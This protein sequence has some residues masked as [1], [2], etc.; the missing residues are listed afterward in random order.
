MLNALRVAVPLQCC[1]SS[2]SWAVVVKLGCGGSGY[3]DGTSGIKHMLLLGAHVLHQGGALVGAPVSGV[4][5]APVMPVILAGNQCELGA[6]H[7]QHSSA[8][9]WPRRYQVLFLSARLPVDCTG[10]S[11]TSRHVDVHTAVPV[12]LQAECPA[13]GLIASHK[14]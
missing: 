6:Q 5:A 13:G 10:C 3:C 7:V 14:H 4:S 8:M 9:S 2:S 12:P 11:C 1:T